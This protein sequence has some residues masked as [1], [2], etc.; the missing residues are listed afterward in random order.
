MI[1]A[2]VPEFVSVTVCAALVVPSVSE[3]KVRMFGASVTGGVVTVTEF[4]PV[5]L[6]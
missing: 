1:R 4:I 3:E 5:E 2:A 6:A